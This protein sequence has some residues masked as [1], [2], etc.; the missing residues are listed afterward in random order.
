MIAINVLKEVE[1]P[2]L[3]ALRIETVV[4]IISG[5]SLLVEWQIFAE[6]NLFAS[7]EFSEIQKTSVVG[8]IKSQIAEFLMFVVVVFHFI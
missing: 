5:T 1:G 7:L 8:D 6:G 3:G 2:V 4:K